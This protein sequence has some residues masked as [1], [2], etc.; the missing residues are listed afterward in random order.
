MLVSRKRFAQSP[1][2]VV[3]QIWN[4]LLEIDASNAACELAGVADTILS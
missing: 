4:G 1:G 3:I 2:V